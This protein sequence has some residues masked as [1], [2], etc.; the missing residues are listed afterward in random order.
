MESRNKNVD[1]LAKIFDK[2]ISEKIEGGI[3]GFAESYSESQG[4]PFLLDSI[5][6][7]KF[8]EILCLLESNKN[9]VNL[10]KEGQIKPEE[11]AFKKAHELNPDKYE[12]INKKKEFEEKNKKDKPTT[13]LFQCP[14]CKKRR[15]TVS[16]KQTRRGDEPAT[17]FIDCLE[18]GHSWRVG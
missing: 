7:E 14:K 16:E 3:L 15:C 11:I 4:T 12:K 2:K 5:Y 10:I 8:N 17:S 9:L 18:C 13:D 1:L 6:Q